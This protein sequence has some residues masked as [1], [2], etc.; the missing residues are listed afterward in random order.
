MAM[1][2]YV[3]LIDF[4]KDETYGHALSNVTY[5]VNEARWSYGVKRAFDEFAPP[6]QCIITLDNS[7]GN[8]D[9]ENTG[10]QFYGLLKRGL[11]V[12]VVGITSIGTYGLFVG[13][14]RELQFDDVGLLGS[15][16]LRLIVTDLTDDLLFTQFDQPLF[17]NVPP[18]QI[19]RDVF[20]RSG[21]VYPY[22]SSFAY[23]DQGYALDGAGTKLFTSAA[24]TLSVGDGQ[25][26]LAYTG[27]KPIDNV[28]AYLRDL[29]AAE[30][31]G[32]FFYAARAGSWTFLERHWAV[33]ATAVDTFDDT[34]LDDIDY[35]VDG[36]V[37]ND[38]TVT[39][40]PR[41]VGTAAS[42][43]WSNP[44]TFEL[45]PKKTRTIT[46]RYTDPNS[47]TGSSVG[48]V[49][50]LQ[51]QAGVDYIGRQN[52]NGSGADYTSSLLL[53]TT[54]SGS[55]A[56]ITI[57]NT[58]PIN[59]V[60]VTLLRVRG[61][62]L[63]SSQPDRVRA[64]SASSQILYNIIARDYTFRLV[65]DAGTAQAFANTVVNR[66]SFARPRVNSVSFN[67]NKN[68]ARLESAHRRFVGEVIRIDSDRLNHDRLYMIV[69]EQHTI[70]GGG[71]STHNVTW[72][73]RP[74]DFYN[75]AVLDVNSL[76]DG[77]MLAI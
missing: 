59:S 40:Y 25:S 26:T 63:I 41:R 4:D 15:R 11:L 56:T 6:A 31:G 44:D 68:P 61:T 39:Y 62:P 73:L 51:P 36:D 72:I 7:A 70:E 30:L 16:K 71:D 53:S 49:D 3:V 42:V 28:Q 58:S 43:L 74:T 37:V 12:K 45:Q 23:L 8:F 33:G 75:Y 21:I 38:V 34:E 50:M 54:F 57:E 20:E 2:E 32:L 27:D 17:R 24:L 10:A 69:G 5:W 65:D 35:S 76:D 46:A 1:A 19:I 9:F 60:F 47:A 18:G 66:F 29:V 77:S 64:F 48:G 52:E 67:A 55:S 22:A 13:R 14:I